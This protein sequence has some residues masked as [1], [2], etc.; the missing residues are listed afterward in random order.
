MPYRPR[1]EKELAR[2]PYRP[3][4]EDTTTMRRRGDPP[5]LEKIER[6]EQLRPRFPEKQSRDEAPKKRA[7]ET[8]TNASYIRR[9]PLDYAIVVLNR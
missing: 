5:R 2:G 7:R 4:R 8:S 6:L 1:T 3:T 9:K